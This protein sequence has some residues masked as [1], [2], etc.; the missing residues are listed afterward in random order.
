MPRLLSCLGV[1]ESAF[2]LDLSFA[3][4]LGIDYA[5][6]ILKQAEERGLFDTSQNIKQLG[7]TEEKFRVEDFALIDFNERLISLPSIL[8]I[9]PIK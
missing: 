3:N 6:T 1:S 7:E 2:A 8:V 9:A 4:I 5:N